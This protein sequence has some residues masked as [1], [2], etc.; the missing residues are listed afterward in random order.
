M[1]MSQDLLTQI[2]NS[3]DP[4]EPLPAGDPAYVDCAEVRGDT[5]ILVDLGNKL[6]RSQR[7][8]CQLY[9]GHRGGGKS[10]ELLRLKDHLEKNGCVVVYFAADEDDIDPEDAEYTDILLS[11]TRHLL[12]GL[13]DADPKPILGWLGDRWNDLKDLALTEISFDNLS[14]EAQITQFAKLT[15][16]IRAIPSERQK[17]RDKVNPHTITLLN[18]LNEFIEDAK[19]K[20]PKD[21]THLVAI[22]DNLDRI[23]LIQKEHGHTNYDEIFLDRA[24]QLQGLNCHV[25]YTI[26]ISMVYSSRASDLRDIYGDPQILPMVMVQTPEGETDEVGTAKIIEII[27]KRIQRPE[28]SLVPDIFASKEGLQRLCLMS[29]GHVRNLMLLVRS[30]IDYIDALPITDRAIQRSITQARDTFRRTVEQEEWQLLAKVSHDKQID[31]AEDYRKLLF[32]RCVLHYVYFD[33]DGE[34]QPWY[35]VHPLIKSIQQFK[36]AVENLRQDKTEQ[37]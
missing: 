30:A 35:D 11:C 4:F 6:L 8:V 32:N 17:I 9:T 18:A 21:K 10:T 23:S 33:D 3:F 31:N 29:G 28:I 2:Y 36:D 13:K 15:A 14:I 37:Q 24:Q 5:N 20:L 25:I 22:A 1:P 7:M 26:P 16:S 34:L 27:T 12:E 19:Q